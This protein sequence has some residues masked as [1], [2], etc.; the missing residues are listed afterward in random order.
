[1]S[2]V[3]TNILSNLS[4]GEASALI[5]LLPFLS[6]LFSYYLFFVGA[7][8]AE[9]L[10]RRSLTSAARVR[11]PAGDLFAVSEKGFVPV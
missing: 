10:A 11:F 1:M 2:E 9:W 7:Q 6:I 5:P 4:T 8:V 3:S